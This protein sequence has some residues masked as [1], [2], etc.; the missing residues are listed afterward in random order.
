VSPVRTHAPGRTSTGER[1]DA[2]DRLSRDAHFTGEQP[3]R[4]RRSTGSRSP[5]PIGRPTEND[6]PPNSAVAG[7]EA[8]DP[9]TAFDLLSDDT[10]L[11]TPHELYETAVSP[12]TSLPLSFSSLYDAAEVADGS[13]FACHLDALA[14]RRRRGT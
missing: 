12:S 8:V 14:E 3:P 6:D 9:A 7:S 2:G 13:T 1:P 4:C 5:G 11:A 10:R